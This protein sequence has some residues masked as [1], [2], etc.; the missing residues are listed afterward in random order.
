MSLHK[1]L[2]DSK[3]IV[4][5]KDDIEIVKGGYILDNTKYSDRLGYMETELEVEVQKHR[6]VNGV[7]IDYIAEK[8]QEKITKLLT[9]VSEVKNELEQ[10]IEYGEH[11]QRFTERDLAFMNEVIGLFQSELFQTNKTLWYDNT[12]ANANI[13]WFFT[14]SNTSII[15]ENANVLYELKAIGMANIQKLFKLA[16]VI[17]SEIMNCTNEELEEYN[18]KERYTELI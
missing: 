11:K 9:E 13:K 7:I 8:R 18:V 17:V 15:L 4:V 16:E 5:A 14:L 12:L 1:I 10:V 2:L 3:G 6:I